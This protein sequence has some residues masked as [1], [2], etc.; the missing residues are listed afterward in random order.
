MYKFWLDPPQ[1]L[2]LD[3]YFFNWT[4]PEEFTNHSSTPKFQEVGPYRFQEFPQKTNVTFH[5]NNSTVG[6]RKQ[7]RYIF[8]PELSRG[9]MTDILTTPNVV[10]LAA[11]NQ[12]RSF[13]ILKVKGVELSL[14]F[15]GQQIYVTKTVSEL[16][17]EGYEDSMVGVAIEIAKI[18]GIDMPFNDN[19]FGWFYEVCFTNFHY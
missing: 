19:R 2:Y 7:S 16:L 1:P 9:K 18:M 3:I 8:I 6:Y 17:F 5:D 4:N 15:F 12:A 11:S 14:A 13:N 10:A